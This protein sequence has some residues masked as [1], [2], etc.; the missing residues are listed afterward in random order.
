MTTSSKLLRTLATASA[1]IAICL[2]SLKIGFAI[3]AVLSTVLLKCA[4]L[5][6]IILKLTLII[7]RSL[8]FVSLFET[9]VLSITTLTMKRSVALIVSWGSVIIIVIIIVRAIIC[10][11][12][13]CLLGFRWVLSLF[14]RFFFRLTLPLV[15]LGFAHLNG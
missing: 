5:K 4:S 14:L 1:S 13:L 10:V 12:F 3:I 6:S 8:A 15:C 9:S 7:L 11:R 2:I